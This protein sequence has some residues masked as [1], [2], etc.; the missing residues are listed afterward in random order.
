MNRSLVIILASLL[1]LGGLMASML[2][3]HSTRAES[4]EGKSLRLYCAASNRAVIERICSSY[5]AESGVK[6]AIEYGASQTLLTSI[7]V[8]GR[9]DLFLPADDS[10]LRLAADKG[11]ITEQVPVARMRL[12][13]CVPQGNP[14]EIDSFDDLLQPHVRVVQAQPDAAAVGKLTRDVLSASRHWDSLNA[15]TAAY[16]STVTEVASD[17]KLG[18]AD[19]GI[20]YDAVLHS[21][22]SLEAVHV[23][24]LEAGVSLVAIGVLRTSQQPAAALNFARYLAARD[25]GQKTYA[26]FG[27][28]PVNGEVR[29]EVSH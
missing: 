14:R 25:R 4:S 12:T 22:P 2:D 21:Y 20:V 6:V 7:E 3:F 5:E 11:L 23:P 27:F 24:E 28:E 16:R 15:H 18:A 29:R 13:L 9:G 10:Y 17:V 8:S 1:L 19:V 26:E